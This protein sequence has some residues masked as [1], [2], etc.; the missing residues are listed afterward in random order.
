[1]FLTSYLNVGGIC[2]P[3]EYW[4]VVGWLDFQA[5]WGWGF[6][7]WIQKENLNWRFFL[8]QGMSSLCLDRLTYSIVATDSWDV[9]LP[10]QT[11]VPRACWHS[12]RRAL[13]PCCVAIKLIWRVIVQALL[14]WCVAVHELAL[15]LTTTSKTNVSGAPFPQSS[16]PL[17]SASPPPPQADACLYWDFN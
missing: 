13:L 11:E 9:V 8:L 6:I 14:S 4:C 12:A 16:M 17:S 3:Q 15:L 5:V 2:L 10:W 1:M 7:K